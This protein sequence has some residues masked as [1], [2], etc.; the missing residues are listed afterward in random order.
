[1]PALVYSPTKCEHCASIIAFI[2]SQPALLSVVKLHNIQT[3]GVPKGVTRVP[4]LIT[5]D[6]KVLVGMDVKKFLEDMIPFDV[7]YTQLGSRLGLGD[8]DMFDLDMYG[9]TLAPPMTSA[10][11]EKIS[12]SV[13]DA[14]QTIKK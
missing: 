12:R 5:D 7:E 14:Y 4:T 8:D 1:M 13:Q 9:Q 11:E 6:G 10:L 3:H 2:T